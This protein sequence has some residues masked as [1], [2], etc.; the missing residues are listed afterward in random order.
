MPALSFELNTRENPMTAYLIVR[1]DVP[2]ADRDAFDRWYE[3]EHLPDAVAAFNARNG[4]RGWS[5]TEPNLHYAWYEFDDLATAMATSDSEAIKGL[6]A[7]FD[8]TWGERIARTRDVVD[9]QQRV[10]GDSHRS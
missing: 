8:R 6:I 5:H 9:C 2:A 3:E 7:A 10:S 1:A 4:W